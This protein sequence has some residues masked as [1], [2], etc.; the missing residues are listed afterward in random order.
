M[1]KYIYLPA[2]KL[3]RQVSQLRLHDRGIEQL[4]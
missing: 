4:A 1:H 2:N 3:G